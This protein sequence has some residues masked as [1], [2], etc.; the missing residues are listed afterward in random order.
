M[1]I[2][3]RLVALSGVSAAGL[4][5]VAAVSYFAVT[6]IQSDL[7]GL[8][9]HA[10][11]LQARTLELQERTERL[12]GGLLKMS[13][14]HGADEATKARAA[15]DAELKAIDALRG[16]IRTLDPNAKLEGADFRAAREQIAKAVERRLVDAESY[17]R[18]TE[19]ARDSLAS[20]A[21]HIG[22]TRVAV[23]QIGVDAGK[24]ADAAQEATRRLGNLTKRAL[25]AQTLLREVA[26]VVAEIDQVP[27]R[28][29]LAPLKEKVKAPLDSLQRLEAE[30]GAEDALKDLRAAAAQMF[31][32][33]AKDGSGLLAARAAVL[34][35]KD[36]AEVAAAYAKQRKAVTDPI[37]AQ[38]A[39]LGALIDGIEVQ[40]V[41]QRQALEAALKLRNEPGGVVNTSEE[42]TLAI[43]DMVGGLRLLMLAAAEDEAEATRTALRQQA[44]ALAQGMKAMQAGLSRMGRPQLAQQVE[45]ALNAMG[46]VVSAIENVAATKK[47]LLASETQMAA[48]LAQLKAV[49]AQQ[50]QLGE[51]QVRS[52]GERQ[53]EVSR[54]VDRRVTSSLVLIVGIAGGIIAVIGALSWFTVRLVTRRLDAAVKVAEEVSQGRLVA[55]EA[56]SGND[57]TARLMAALG[58]MV[59][60]LSG[61][62]GEI[63]GAA[64]Q[65]DAGSSEISRGNQDLSSRTEQQA[66]ALQQTAAS[67]E[68]LT[69]TVR[70]NAES[71]RV[72]HGLAGEASAVAER[73]GRVVGEVVTTMQGIAD[74]SQKIA[75]IIGVIDAI[76]FQTNLLA[77][78]AAVEAA[79]AGEN[80]RG[81]AVV[82]AEVRTL[83][84][85]CAEAAA[86]VKTLVTQSVERVEAGAGLVQGAGSTME[87]IVRQVQR[88]NALI[89]EIARAS[90]E[91][92]ASVGTVGGAVSHLD[93]MTQQNAALAEQS[94]AAA[95]SLRSQ[96][97]GLT[98][99]IAVFEHA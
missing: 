14:A 99:A 51:Q 80:G 75:E 45:D 15:V 18:E 3:H 28:F 82:A 37:E 74:A 98:R 1:K 44:Q 64:E 57:E 79:R 86:Q 54:A 6:S 95:M 60:T 62:V 46:G 21:K 49:A 36:D 83:A 22:A 61:I 41:K 16:E 70:Q 81:F 24:A 31:E 67:V 12:L 94:T 33:I 92:A 55:V 53:A 85:K 34:A 42:V 32:A 69:A 91:Q 29:R 40:A 8:T 2:S 9:L 66:S 23:A 52:V 65:I 88:V 10:A 30:P 39:K 58:S 17:R 90:D 4:L 76:A 77:L 48:S 73:G 71:A 78:N 89:A 43:R 13:L 56:G 59:A 63:R 25:Q 27:N 96:A 7:Q 26:L 19:T 38:S 72:A 50:S 35:K 97:E 84:G 47:R 5:C 68:E 87:E 11:P 93:R 20:A